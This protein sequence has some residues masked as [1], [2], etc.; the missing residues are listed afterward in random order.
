MTREELI[1]ICD[2]ART[3]LP[4]LLDAEKRNEMLRAISAALL[5]HK[6][7]ILAANSKDVEAAKAA[8]ITP[9]MI[10]RLTL[11]PVRIDDA[12]AAVL[13]VA[14]L[15]DPLGDILVN[16]RPNGLKI[17]LQKVPLGV[18]AMVYEA[19]PNVTIDAA[20]LCIRSGNAVVLRGGKEAINS[21]IALVG[22]MRGA[23]ESY[24]A[25]DAVNLVTDTS[26]ESVNILMTLRGHIDLIIPRGGAG[27]IRN[28]VDNS[29]VPVI[30]TGAG[31]CHVYVEKSAD[32]DMAVNIVVNAKVS[33]PSVC[34]AAETLLCDEAIAP[35]F[36]PVAAKALRERGVELRVCGESMK[37]IPDAKA[38]T[39]EDYATEFNDYI[40]AV[41]IVSG[42]KEA[43][44]HINKYGTKH[45]EAIVTSDDNAADYFLTNV[46][47]AA[48]YRNA[49]TRFT[50]GGVFGM[51]AEIGIS[52]QK[53]HARGPFGLEALT[54]TKYK[55]IGSGQ[56]R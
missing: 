26:R 7:E 33:R 35:A 19:R 4:R 3:V 13:E 27:L 6:D 40:L 24:G 22:I 37:Y 31:N 48:V 51:G 42:V 53:L 20:A 25:S 43:V 39:E 54:T 18:I 14:A 32:I 16:N 34:N 9:A 15:P 12:A 8:G 10:D 21:N 50:D 47:A 11:T 45:S 49:S 23:L 55:V 5:A 29:R 2:G 41:K 46:D 1:K 17:I 28:V 30:E 52:T 44:E 38:A 56:V 36:L